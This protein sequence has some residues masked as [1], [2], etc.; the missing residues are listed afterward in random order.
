MATTA[1]D[2]IEQLRALPLGEQ[3]KVFDALEK[4][5][6]LAR[7]RE[8]QAKFAHTTNSSE[9]F[10]RRKADEIELEERKFQSS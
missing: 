3:R 4:E 7:I 6:R 9:D 10:A 1:H 5:S 8:V 2:I